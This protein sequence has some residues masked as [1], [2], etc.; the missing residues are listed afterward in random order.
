MTI[1]IFYLHNEKYFANWSTLKHT[2]SSCTN[3]F[4]K[5]QLL[6]KKNVSTSTG[7]KPKGSSY[8][9]LKFIFHRRKTHGKNRSLHS[10]DQH[11]SQSDLPLK[12]IELQE[13]G[14]YI[15]LQAAKLPVCGN[16][17]NSQINGTLP[18]ILANSMNITK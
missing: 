13:T 9:G 10:K 2:T 1:L 18:K 6:G 7:K 3:C 15:I 16:L 14:K 17:P 4:K 5:Q 11:L 12:R 8:T